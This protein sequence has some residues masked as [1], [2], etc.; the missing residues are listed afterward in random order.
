MYFL[1]KSHSIRAYVRI[2]NGLADYTEWYFVESY[3]NQIL[4]YAMACPIVNPDLLNSYC[5]LREQ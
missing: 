5:R 1:H 2:L 4:I 3:A